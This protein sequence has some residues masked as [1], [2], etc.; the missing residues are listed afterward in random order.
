MYIL[1]TLAILSCFSPS[2]IA[3]YEAGFGL[4]MVGSNVIMS[5]TIS[6]V[7]RV[8]PAPVIIPSAMTK[9]HCGKA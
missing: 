5:T 3:R 8:S 7:E 1:T 4:A 2:A 9:K 6:G